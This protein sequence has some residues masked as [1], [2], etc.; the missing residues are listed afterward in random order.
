MHKC[1]ALFAVVIWC[2]LVA[3]GR[4]SMAEDFVTGFKYES[5][6]IRCE[7]IVVNPRELLAEMTEEIKNFL[8]RDQVLRDTLDVI[9]Y[10]KPN[11]IGHKNAEGR[12][13]VQYLFATQV[14]PD[15]LLPGEGG[16]SVVIEAC[17]RKVEF[18]NFFRYP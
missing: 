5:Y 11:L 4:Y 13:L 12:V 15:V 6:E 16:V 9:D 7:G 17:R 14:Q 1:R 3:C 2:S 18:A 8:S 10:T